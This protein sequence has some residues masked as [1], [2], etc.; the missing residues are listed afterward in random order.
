MIFQLLPIILWY[1]TFKLFYKY[2]STII[3]CLQTEILCFDFRFVSI[4]CL[5]S[6]KCFVFSFSH[7]RSLFLSIQLFIHTVLMQK[8]N[9]HLKVGKYTAIEI[10]KYNFDL[11]SFMILYLQIKR[12]FFFC[13]KRWYFVFAFATYVE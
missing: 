4:K 9:N 6:L 13:S 5:C 2:Q 12:N 8:T 11:N 10:N 3:V 7:F 1:E